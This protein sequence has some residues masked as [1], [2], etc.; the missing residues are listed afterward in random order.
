MFLID[1]LRQSA[2]MG[3]SSLCGGFGCHFLLGILFQ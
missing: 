1:L 3:G 2:L